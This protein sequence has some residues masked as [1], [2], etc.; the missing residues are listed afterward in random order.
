MR[1]CKQNYCETAQFLQLR[2]YEKMPQLK[3]NKSLQFYA[4]YDLIGAE[5]A[6]CYVLIMCQFLLMALVKLLNEPSKLFN[7]DD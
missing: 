1:V 3:K 4:I 6:G 7:V 2:N 5:I